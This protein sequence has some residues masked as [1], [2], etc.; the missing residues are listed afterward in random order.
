[1]LNSPMEEKPTF[2]QLALVNTM[3]SGKTDKWS[4][5]TYGIAVIQEQSAV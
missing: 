3:A 4:P 2:G 5:P 1:L